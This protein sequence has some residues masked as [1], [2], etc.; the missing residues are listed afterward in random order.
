MATTEEELKQ[1][2]A[3]TG[4]GG[5]LRNLYA[6]DETEVARM[7][8]ARQADDEMATSAGRWRAAQRLFGGTPEGPAPRPS[9]ASE[10]LLEERTLRQDL[11]QKRQG[12]QDTSSL[13]AYLQRQGL[14]PE[15]AAVMAR[16]PK[17]LDAW[18]RGRGQ[19]EDRDWR[20]EQARLD[21]EFRAGESAKDRA[22]RLRAARESAKAQKAPDNRKAATD[23]RKEFTAH[24][25]VKRYQDI[26]ISYDKVKRAAQRANTSK[27]EG[28]RA[29]SDLSL[30]FGFMKMLDPGSV[31]R[32]GE[33]ATAQNAAGVPDRIR[34][35]YNRALSGE[36]LNPNQRNGFLAAAEDAYRAES[37][38]YQPVADMYGRLAGAQG[39]DP[40]DILGGQP[41]RPTQ[42]GNVDITQPTGAVRMRSPDGQVYEIDPS[43]AQDAIANGWEPL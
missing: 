8:Q 33:F 3:G 34:N 15:D 40:A 24:P 26:Q 1:V 32:E 13:T 21:R 39:L 30:V 31:V 9:T 17:V 7:R 29:A 6:E 36:I 10:R 18:N 22:A 25:V 35:A 5:A 28:E 27:S 41:Q 42:G 11:A 14:S 23:L 2:R 37:A 16:S 19:Q 12:E 20:A 4:M 38:T 43:E